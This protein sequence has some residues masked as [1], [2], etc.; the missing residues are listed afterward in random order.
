MG[1]WTLGDV[2]TWKHRDMETSNGEWKPSRFFLLR[3]L[4]THHAKGSLFLDPFFHEEANGNYPLQTTKR[5][6]PSMLRGSL[7][8]KLL[9]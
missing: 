8:I 3:L 5:T 1:T 7:S 4:V 9:S 6:C 2:V